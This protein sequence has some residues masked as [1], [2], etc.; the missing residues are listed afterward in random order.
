MAEFGGEPT[1]APAVSKARFYLDHEVG[2][3]SVPQ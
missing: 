1:L 3:V 2:I